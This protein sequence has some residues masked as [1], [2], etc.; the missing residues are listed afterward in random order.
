MKK[1]NTKIHLERVYLDRPLSMWTG[2]TYLE[3]GQRNVTLLQYD[4]GKHV[5]LFKRGQD[6]PWAIPMSN[7]VCFQYADVKLGAPSKEKVKEPFV[8]GLPEYPDE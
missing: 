8:K 6:R 3:L 4:M 5:V 2:V 1:S 7:V